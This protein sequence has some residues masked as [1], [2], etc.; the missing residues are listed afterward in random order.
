MR[1]IDKAR[2]HPLRRRILMA[3]RER[4]RLLSPKR[5]AESV[6]E[7]VTNVSYHFRVLHQ[8]GLIELADQQQVRGATEHFYAPSAAF[9]AQIQDTVAMDRI[10]EIL[11]DAAEAGEL[12]PASLAGKIVPILL[13]TGRP[14]IEEGL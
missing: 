4:D 1:A 9:T 11:E 7:K 12:D 3:M 13:A 6:G 14:V 8:V 5:F 2:S 10:T